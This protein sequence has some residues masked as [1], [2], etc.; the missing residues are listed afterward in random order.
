MERKV[1]LKDHRT[2]TLIAFYMA[3][4]W[5]AARESGDTVFESWAS[6][7]LLMVEQWAIDNGRSQAA[8]LLS[9]LP[10]PDFAQLQARRADLRGWRSQPGLLRRW[11]RP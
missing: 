6:C 4:M 8:W 11:P 9:G 3:H 5:E 10:D 1:P 2:L 7:G